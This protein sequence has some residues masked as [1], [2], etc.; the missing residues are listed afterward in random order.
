MKYKTFFI[1][2][3]MLAW[4]ISILALGLMYGMEAAGICLISGC[5]IAVAILFEEV[6]HNCMRCKR[7]QKCECRM[8]GE[9]FEP[10]ERSGDER[11]R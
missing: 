7:Y 11:R 5:A 10:V 1:A 6:N 4:W 2:L 8:S 9:G 3:A